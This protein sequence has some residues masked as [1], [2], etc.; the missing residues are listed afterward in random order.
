MLTSVCPEAIWPPARVVKA[1][2]LRLYAPSCFPDTY[3]LGRRIPLLTPQD[4]HPFPLYAEYL[5]MTPAA[6]NESSPKHA[7]SGK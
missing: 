1:V 5:L 7:S 3:S 6:P 4:S 2:T